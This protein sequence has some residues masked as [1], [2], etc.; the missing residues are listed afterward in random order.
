VSG[1]EPLRWDL[2]DSA[3]TAL[4]RAFAD[5][6]MFRW[7]IP[8]PQHRARSLRVMNRGP[9]QYAIRYGHAMQSHRGLAVAAWLPPRCALT[10]FRTISCGILG[11]PFRVG[12][13]AF[14]RFRHA[15]EVLAK[16]HRKHVPEPH[17]YLM[18]VGVDPE[19]QGRGLG[20]A[21]VKDG[22]ARA[23]RENVPCYLETAEERNL[24]FYER[25][26][27][28]VVEATALATGGPRAWAMRRNP[29]RDGAIVR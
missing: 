19:L 2:L 28:V 8:D 15:N 20:T 4:T 18:V 10:A 12:F 9:L 11:V 5:E 27:F 22:L 21:L 1:I 17:W 6:P 23:D 14:R 16:I 3:T 13:H 26:G 29:G 24:A 7:V 25:L